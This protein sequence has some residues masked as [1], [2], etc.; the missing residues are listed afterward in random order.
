MA[1]GGHGALRAVFRE[2]RGGGDPG[3][4]DPWPR[5]SIG[6]QRARACSLNGWAEGG[7]TEELGRVTRGELWGSGGVSG[8]RVQ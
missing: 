7:F 5:G 2:R 3:D 6:V 8:G 4:G 1:A